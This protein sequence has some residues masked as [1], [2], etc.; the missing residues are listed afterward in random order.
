MIFII[1]NGF[2]DYRSNGFYFFF[3]WF[4]NKEFLD[5]VIE[6]VN[7]DKYKLKIFVEISSIW[8]DKMLNLWLNWIVLEKSKL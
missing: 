1:W 4:G 6:Y 7:Y 5:I 8:G 2:N 3:W